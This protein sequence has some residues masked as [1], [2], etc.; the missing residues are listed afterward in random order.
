MSPPG[1]WL[2][3]AA[4]CARLMVD[5]SL[6]RTFFL[7]LKLLAGAPARWKREMLCEWT[8][9]LNVWHQD[10]VTSPDDYQDRHMI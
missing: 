5:S 7:G 1:W 3:L 10:P 9:D 6:S 4:Y 2:H 8:E